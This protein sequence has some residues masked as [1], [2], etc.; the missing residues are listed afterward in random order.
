M[1]LT[2]LFSNLRPAPAIRVPGSRTA[3][4]VV[5]AI[6][7]VVS[8]LVYIA[9]SP[10]LANPKLVTIS[11]QGDKT[12]SQIAQIL[13]G[14]GVS[15]SDVK[16]N[17]SATPTEAEKMAF[18]YFTD[19][20][21]D[22]GISQGLVIGANQ[23][24]SVFSRNPANSPS[25]SR[26]TSRSF[27]AGSPSGTIGRAL[28]DLAS[29]AGLSRSV[30]S[31]NNTTELEFTVTPTDNFLKFEYVL[32][33]TEVDE[34]AIQYPD[35]DVNPTNITVDNEIITIFG[36]NLNTVTAV[37]IGGIKVKIFSQ[38]GNR[39]QVK[40]PK[41]LSGAVDLE[42]KSA[43]NDV[44]IRAKIKYGEVAASE[45]KAVLIVG[46]FDHNSRKLTK[47][48]KAKISRWLDRNS[49]LSTLTCTGFT[50]LPRRTKDV[51][52]ST[53]RGI[54]ACNFSKRE[55]SELETSVSQGIE[56]PRPGSNVRRVRLVLTP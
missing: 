26:P 16:I 11:E 4:A 45:R 36:A 50:S 14:A 34:D 39:L 29:Q 30:S 35:V 53:N 5:A 43:L 54:T 22:I 6:G 9:F 48:M 24:A 32:A 7:M 27:D 38:S 33:I 12:P 55:R 25:F 21:D 23:R 10:S 40:A 20:E 19:G 44:L 31:V 37:Y 52:L 15:F 3:V 2:K 51:T 47:K 8:S 42:L 49:D 18:G 17:G 1:P 56:D 13:A 28:F 46:G 41:G